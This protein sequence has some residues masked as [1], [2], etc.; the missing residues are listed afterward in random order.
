MRITHLKQI[1]TSVE[2]FQ[3]PIEGP[4]HFKC[5]AR[6]SAALLEQFFQRSNIFDIDNLTT[7]DETE[8]KINGRIGRRSI[9]ALHPHPT[10]SKEEKS[11]VKSIDRAT[12]EAGMLTGTD[13]PSL[14][15]TSC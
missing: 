3:E 2:T 1:D 14:L 10:N 12:S 6:A 15:T 7:A 4:K 9:S 13:G 11:R 8:A 5:L